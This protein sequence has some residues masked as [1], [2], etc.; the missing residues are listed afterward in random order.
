MVTIAK[1]ERDLSTLRYKRVTQDV[2]L[3]ETEKFTK[4]DLMTP[5]RLVAV[6]IKLCKCH[7]GYSRVHRV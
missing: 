2:S 3:T 6:Y 7:R 1:Y 5:T 4:R